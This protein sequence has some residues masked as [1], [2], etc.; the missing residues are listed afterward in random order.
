MSVADFYAD[1][2]GPCKQL[3]PIVERIASGTDA[4]VAKVDIEANQQLAT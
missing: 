2:Y 1:W 3:E 4:T